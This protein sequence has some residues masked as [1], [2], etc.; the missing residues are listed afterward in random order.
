LHFPSY[1]GTLPEPTPA[2]TA[3]ISSKAFIL[4]QEISCMSRLLCA[5]FT[6]ATVLGCDA[7]RQ[8]L[9][10]TE[11]PTYPEHVRRVIAK[12]SIMRGMT[13]NQVY[14]SLGAPVC[15]KDIEVQGRSLRVWLYPPIGRDACATADFRVYFENGVVATWDHFTKATRFTDPPGGAP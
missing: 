13:E 6:L 11:Y 9:L 12:E 7:E 8:R 2:S 14:L 10:E 5:V 1:S 4:D 3:S 15:K